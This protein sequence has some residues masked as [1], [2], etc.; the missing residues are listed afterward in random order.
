M[1]GNN[2]GHFRKGFDPR[3]HKLTRAERR[4]GYQSLMNGGVNNLPA[5][6]IAWAWRKV[7][8]YYRAKV[9]RRA[10]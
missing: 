1:K 2:R 7:R 3:R 8:A 6:Q 9:S 5:E 10:G 4:R